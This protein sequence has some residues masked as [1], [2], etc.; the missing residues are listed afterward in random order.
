MPPASPSTTS[1][2]RCGRARHERASPPHAAGSH[3]SITVRKDESSMALIDLR[4]RSEGA[5]GQPVELGRANVVAVALLVACLGAGILATLLTSNPVPLV[6]F[7]IA[8]FV[9]MQAPK[10]AQQWERAV[11]L[12]L[13]RFDGL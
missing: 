5:G 12:K 4:R 10:V 11:V 6:I 2:T 3:R 7:A 1:W 13:G 9:L 8:G